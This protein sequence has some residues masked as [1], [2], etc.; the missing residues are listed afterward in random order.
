[1]AKIPAAGLERGVGGGG[2]R[3]AF[4]KNPGSL[5]LVVFSLVYSSPYFYFVQLIS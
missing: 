2:C 3:V 4:I 1:M 5:Y